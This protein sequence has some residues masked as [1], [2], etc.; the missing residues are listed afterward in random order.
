MQ[1]KSIAEC[2]KGSNLQYFDLH[3]ATIC[4][5][6]LCFVYFEWPFY[7]DFTVHLGKGSDKQSRDSMLIE[8]ICHTHIWINYF[9]CFNV[10]ITAKSAKIREIFTDKHAITFEDIC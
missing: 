7:R 10:K 6:D 8:K 2:S 4:H 9:S 5:Y 3:L 1:V